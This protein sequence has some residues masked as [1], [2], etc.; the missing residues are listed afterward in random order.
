[1]ND[2]K[3]KWYELACA[4]V[5]QA[6]KDYETYLRKYKNSKAKRL[7]DNVYW[8]EDAKRFL[9]DGSVDKLCDIDGRKIAKLV[10]YKVE[11][12]ERI[13]FYQDSKYTK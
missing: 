2:T 8:G 10:E 9:Y 4:I 7:G 13:I 11:H 5:I 6:I 12:N 1:M 3:N